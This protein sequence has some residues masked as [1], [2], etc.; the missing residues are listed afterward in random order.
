VFYVVFG[1]LSDKV[2][3]KPVMLGGMTLALAFYFPG[4]HLLE[5]AANPALAEAS[6]KSP[7]TVTADPAGLRPAVRPRRQGRLRLVVRHRQERP[8]Q[9]RDLLRQPEGPGRLGG[10][11]PGRRD[12]GRLA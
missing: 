5:R 8:G 3:R 9:C 7:V 2:G 6:A 12:A 10:G 4:F 11:D 1:W